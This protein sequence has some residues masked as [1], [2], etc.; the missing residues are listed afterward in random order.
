[1][2]TEFEY[3][4]T[5]NR[6]KANKGVKHRRRPKHDETW[7]IKKN[8]ALHVQSRQENEFDEEDTIH[9]ECG[10][11]NSRWAYYHRQLLLDYLISIH[12]W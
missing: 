3:A 10:R 12:G 4:K 8:I 1:M 5:V 11:G 9:S 6:F 2:F 7:K